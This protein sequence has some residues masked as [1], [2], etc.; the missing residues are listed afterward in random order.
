MT[1]G[2]QEFHTLKLKRIEEMP[3]R[4]TV[5]DTDTGAEIEEQVRD[6]HQRISAFRDGE[7]EER[8]L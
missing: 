4:V 3:Q 2:T 1:N 5:R 7:V 6:L 8:H